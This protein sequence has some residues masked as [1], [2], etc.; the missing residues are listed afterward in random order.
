MNSNL[1][2]K[3]L[4]GNATPQENAEVYNWIKKSEINESEFLALRKLH[5]ICIWNENSSIEG[6]EV[7]RNTTKRFLYNIIRIAGVF[8]LGILIFYFYQKSTKKDP[9]NIS[10]IENP[11]L[12]KTTVS[13]G[14]YQELMLEDG[15]K[16]W[17]NSRSSLTYPTKFNDSERIVT[18]DGEGYFAVN[19]DVYRPF[20]VITNGYTIEVLGTEFNV[21]SYQN[22]K[23][24]S[25]ETSLVKG[26][27]LIEEAGSSQKLYLN[28][29][30]KAV[31]TDSNMQLCPLD[32]NDFLWREGILFIDNKTFN[33]IIP[34]LEQYFGI[35]VVIKNDV[36]KKQKKYTGKFRMEEGV[37]QI[38]DVFQTQYGFTYE[39]EKSNHII[40]K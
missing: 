20:K 12:E 36:S 6:K 9:Q 10:M 38:L 7:K 2:K 26:R 17:L 13:V 34:I 27:V 25:F 19:H 32:K 8:L 23:Y 16:I 29:N 33:E 30:E 3:Y 15:T 24:T 5:D 40:I 37:E 14:Q 1:L 11:I 28:P 22:P 4:D 35:K 18:L 39:K 21:K 31:K